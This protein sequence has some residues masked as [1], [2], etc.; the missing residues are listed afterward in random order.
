MDAAEHAAV[1][2]REIE[3]RLFGVGSDVR[4]SPRD[5]IH[6]AFNV[7]FPELT[8][9]DAWFS[10]AAI[11]GLEDKIRAALSVEPSRTVKV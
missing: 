6:I 1:R 4:R 10:R 11:D 8:C 5:S 3:R 2:A 7:G 9:A